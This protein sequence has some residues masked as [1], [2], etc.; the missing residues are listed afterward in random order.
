MGLLVRS[1]RVKESETKVNGDQDWLQSLFLENYYKFQD[2]DIRAFNQVWGP[3]KHKDL[4]LW[5]Q[6]HILMKLAWTYIFN[7]KHS[8]WGSWLYKWKICHKSIIKHLNFKH[9][10]G[11]YTSLSTLCI[12]GI[13]WSK[14][15]K[16]I[17]KMLNQETFR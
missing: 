14:M 2:S 8:K 12:T 16:T 15:L 10:L 9:R 3:S 6:G 4:D 5:L 7:L 1:K 13:F 17:F 11:H